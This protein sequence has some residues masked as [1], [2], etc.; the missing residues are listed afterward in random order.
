MGKTRSS[1]AAAGASKTT[2]PHRMSSNWEGSHVT[3]NDLRALAAIGLLPTEEKGIW[4]APGDERVPSPREGELVF[5]TSHVERGLAVEGSKFFRELLMFYGLRL[6]DIAPNSILQVSAFTFLCEAYLRVAPS[7]GL[8][9]E[10]F[11]GKQQTESKGGAPLELG[12][13]SFQRRPR[14]PYPKPKFVKKVTGWTKTFFYVKNTVPA[15]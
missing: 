5:F 9:L 10:T 14:A 4:R 15:H 11:F 8:W 3:E 12:A 1:T 2:A 6:H 13:I 7:M